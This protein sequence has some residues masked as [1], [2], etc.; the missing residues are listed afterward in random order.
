MPK[1]Q[2]EITLVVICC[3]KILKC[4][5]FA[6]TLIN[7]LTILS[8]L[9]ISFL[10]ILLHVNVHLFLSFA[11]ISAPLSCLTDQPLAL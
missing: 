10:T 1:S 8:I 11:D 7:N 9:I 5:V 3:K 4:I 2:K 6:L